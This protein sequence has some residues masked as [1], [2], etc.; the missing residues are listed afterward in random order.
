MSWSSF[1]TKGYD[2]VLAETIGMQSAKGDMINA[3][4]ARPLGASGP[5]PS[6]VL[7]HHLPGWD[8]FYRETARRFAQQGYSVMCPNLYYRF[9]GGTPDEATAAARAAGGA[10]DDD[11]LA[12]CQGAASFLRAQPTSNGKVGIVG[13]CSG[14]RHAY[15]VACRTQNYDAIVD[16]WGGGVVQAELTPQRPVA[17]IDMTKDL[18]CPILGLFGN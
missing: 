17:P 11:V 7:V 10:S 6:I 9:G 16:M 4:Y 12:D 1:D 14:G 3:Y 13:T 15:M 8:E 18:N 2:G 5:L